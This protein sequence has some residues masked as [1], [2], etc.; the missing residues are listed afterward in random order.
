MGDAVLV[1]VG[2]GC[3]W[4]KWGVEG[5]GWAVGGVSRNKK[6]VKVFGYREYQAEV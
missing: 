4:W 5:C 2:P 1:C 6:G 3:G